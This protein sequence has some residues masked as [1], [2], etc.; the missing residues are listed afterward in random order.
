MADLQSVQEVAQFSMQNE[1]HGNLPLS[2]PDSPQQYAG[3]LLR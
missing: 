1:K 3:I 2:Q